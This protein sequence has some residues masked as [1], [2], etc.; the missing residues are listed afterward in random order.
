LRFGPLSEREVAKVLVERAGTERASASAL[1]ATSGG[2]VSRAL[3][4]QSGDLGD[5][6]D[7]ALA[8]LAAAKGRVTD[9]LKASAAFAKNDS[10]RRDREALA[11][12]LDVLA[13]LLRDLGALA[14][15]SR[16]ALAN[17]DLETDLRSLSAAF[18]IARV[19]AGYNALNHA[20]VALER[21]A[22]PKIVA[23]W[24]ALHL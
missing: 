6:R 22:S 8:V 20:Q 18:P 21:N 23:D 14:S 4:E 9:Q 15:G 7:A 17:A 16:D 11:A 19:S 3:A 24:V 2:S 5:D 12:R 1:A 13:S 10:D